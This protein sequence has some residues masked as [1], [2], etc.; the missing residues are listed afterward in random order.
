MGQIPASF[1][2]ACLGAAADSFETASIELV[3]VAAVV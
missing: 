3:V 1:P 2:S